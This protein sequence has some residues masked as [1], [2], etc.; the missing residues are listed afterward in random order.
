[1]SSISRHDA[2]V[3]QQ[4]VPARTGPW[5]LEHAG[6]FALLI[7]DTIH[8]EPARGKGPNGATG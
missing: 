7:A 6:G 2:G 4:A 1:M 8:A 5:H 3:V